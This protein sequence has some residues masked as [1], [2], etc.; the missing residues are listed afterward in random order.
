[1]A[2]HEK[3]HY[4]RTGQ[5]MSGFSRQF[6]PFLELVNVVGMGVEPEMLDP[7]NKVNAGLIGLKLRK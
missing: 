3:E 1:M 5:F 2:T 6:D 4:K 7:S